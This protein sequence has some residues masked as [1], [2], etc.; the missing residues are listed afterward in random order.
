MEYF[1]GKNLSGLIGAL[2]LA[3]GIGSLFAP[4]FAGWMYDISGTYAVPIIVGA[5]ANGIAALI[6]TRLPRKGTP[7]AVSAA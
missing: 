7:Q 5:V 6:A 3:A 1:G 2:Y 4:V